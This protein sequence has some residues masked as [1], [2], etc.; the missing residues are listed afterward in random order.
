MRHNHP[1]IGFRP[2][3]AREFLQNVRV[4]QTME[5]VAHQTFIPIVPGERIEFGDLRRLPV[6]CGIETR[7]LWQLGI[8]PLNRL[9]GFQ[10]VRQMFG[11]K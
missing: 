10:F 4:G 9:Y 3:L 8:G 2:S 11:S 5:A 1:S 6:K 7:Y